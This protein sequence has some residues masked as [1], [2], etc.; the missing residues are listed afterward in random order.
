MMMQR[1]PFLRPLLPHQND[2]S[3]QPFQ[4][5]NSVSRSIAVDPA[6]AEYTQV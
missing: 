5:N 1:A 3:R 2:S 6:I 4:Q